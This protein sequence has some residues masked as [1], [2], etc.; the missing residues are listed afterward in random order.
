MVVPGVHWAGRRQKD[1]VVLANRPHRGYRR[2]RPPDVPDP[3]GLGGHRALPRPP[4]SG[5]GAGRRGLHPGPVRDRRPARA[6]ACADG[7]SVWN[8][9]ARHHAPADR[10]RGP[11]GADTGSALAGITGGGGRSGRQ[12]GDGRRDLRWAHAGPRGHAGRRGAP[13]RRRFLAADV[14]GERF[15][16]GLQHGP[17]VPDGRGPRA[18]SAPGHEV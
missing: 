17:G 8:P 4:R 16:G 10:R 13:R 11:A 2:L 18:P 6:G 9:D 15:V 1:G 14:L 3:A 12:R 7:T 5:G